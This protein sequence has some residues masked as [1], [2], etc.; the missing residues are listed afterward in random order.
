MTGTKECSTV[1][2]KVYGLKFK[3]GKAPAPGADVRAVVGS[4][5]NS[6]DWHLSKKPPTKHLSF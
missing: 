3:P 1:Q 6:T 5:G 4:E 2:S